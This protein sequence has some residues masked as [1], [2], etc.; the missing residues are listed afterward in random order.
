MNPSTE[1]HI[2][3]K[4]PIMVAAV[5]FLFSALT[6]VPQV[7]M[8]AFLFLNST[9]SLLPDA[10]WAHITNLGDTLQAIALFSII[11]YK[12]PDFV[13]ST[14][15]WGL[16]CA[17]IIQGFKHGLDLPRPNVAL[18]HSLFHLIGEGRDSPS[19]PSGHTATGMFFVALLATTSQS[20]KA[21]LAWVG[22]GVLVGLSRVAI[23]VHWPADVAV[24]AF[25]GWITGFYGQQL[26]QKWF[27]DYRQYKTLTKAL[28]FLPFI[29][30]PYLLWGYELSYSDLF[31]VAESK[32][33]FLA[34][35]VLGTLI[36]LRNLLPQ[37]TN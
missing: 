35:S 33:L 23:G 28:V 2:C 11:M 19:M 7:N 9:F 26:T 25:V 30:I 27:G 8:P 34:I 13:I 18:D 15:L 1:P 5:L 10:F 4:L 22:L 14:L 20:T 3:P 12:R 17:L 24:G 16:V 36:Y 6:L 29:C 21:F 32:G 31:F 37:K